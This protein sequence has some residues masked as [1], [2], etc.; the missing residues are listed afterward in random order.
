MT[1]ALLLPDP[2]VVQTP[3]REAPEAWTEVR[4]LAAFDHARRRCLTECPALD[5]CERFARAAGPEAWHGPVVLA[6]RLCGSGPQPTGYDQGRY[7]FHG[8]DPARVVAR[9]E[10]PLSG[11]LFCVSHDPPVLMGAD[12]SGRYRCRECRLGIQGIDDLLPDPLPQRIFVHP[13][14]G[15]RRNTPEML[16]RRLSWG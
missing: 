14:G 15:R 12:G 13:A 5:A 4:T 9:P 1:T 16:R 10:A 7:T 6:G 3:C 8:K 2:D 11:R